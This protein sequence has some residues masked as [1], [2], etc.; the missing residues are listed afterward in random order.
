MNRPN[1]MQEVQEAVRKVLNKPKPRK[2]KQ[3]EIFVINEKKAVGKPRKELTKGQKQ[4]MKEHRE[5]HTKK[6]MT[7]MTALM[8]A[9]K[10]F[11]T[12]HEITMKKVGR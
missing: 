7:M 10:C 2:K 8:K 1:T 11:Q 6:H 5:H 3:K 9:G 12:A 4:L